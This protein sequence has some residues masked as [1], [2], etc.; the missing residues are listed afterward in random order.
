MDFRVQNTDSASGGDG[1]YFVG[2]QL[3]TLT[4]NRW[5]HVCL[6]ADTWHYAVYFDGHPIGAWPF[7]GEIDGFIVEW[8]ETLSNILQFAP[9]YWSPSADIHD[10]RFYSDRLLRSEILEVADLW[11]GHG[12]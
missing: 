3:A 2:W 4:L 7:V 9:D 8:Y 5:V 10:A 11:P 1:A 12:E 6:V